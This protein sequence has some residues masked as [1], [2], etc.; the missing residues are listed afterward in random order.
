MEPVYPVVRTKTSEYSKILL[1]GAYLCLAT[2]RLLRPSAENVEWGALLASTTHSAIPA[3]S[4]THLPTIFAR[5][6]V[7]QECLEVT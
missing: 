4:D 5:T 3:F 6:F 1:S 2:S 7:R